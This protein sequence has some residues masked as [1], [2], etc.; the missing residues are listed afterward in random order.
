MAECP[1][2]FTIARLAGGDLKASEAATLQH[3]IGTCPACQRTLED[4]GKNLADFQ[5]V[6][7]EQRARLRSKLLEAEAGSGPW[8]KRVVAFALG[9]AAISAILALALIVTLPGKDTDQ[10]SFKGSFS[11]TVVAKRAD[12][13]FLVRDGE[14]L[15]SGDALRLVVVTDS[16]GYLSVVLLDAN[17]KLAWFYPE[18]DPALHPDP[19]PIKQQGR[20][21]LPGSIVLDDWVGEEYLIVVFAAEKF[22]RGQLTELVKREIL[23]GQPVGLNPARLGIRGAVEVLRIQKVGR[24]DP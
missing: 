6:R 21:E 9:A 12:R 19:L 13:Q 14:E 23:G 16:P 7:G 15:T 5:L 2:R 20:S 4:V 11:L 8:R 18:S 1:G 17:G 3:H 24:K 10:E 22:D